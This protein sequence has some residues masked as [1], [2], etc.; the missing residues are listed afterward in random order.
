MKN[1]KFKIFLIIIAIFGLCYFSINFI[2]GKDEYAKYKSFLT[3]E[4]RETIKKYLFPSK[5][6]E[7][8]KYIISQKDIEIS[9]LIS[10]L[11]K[12]ELSYK[13]S[14]KEIVTEKYEK[15]K[16]SN[17]KILKKYNLLQGFYS[18]IA[19]RYP[20]SGYIDFHNSNLFLIS[21]RGLLVFASQFEEKIYF[22]QIKN[23]IGDF[24]GI[25]QFKKSYKYSIKDLHIYENKI[26]VSFTEEIKEDCWNT[27]ILIGE[28]NYQNIFF[29]KL[30]SS[31][32]CINSINNIDNEFEIHQSGGRIIQYDVDNILF[33]I[34]D[35]RSRFLSQDKDS[36]NG[37]IIKINLKTL[38]YDLFSMGHRNPQ[39]LY[40]D[41]EKNL[42]FETEH[43]PKG[44][45]EINLLEIN[46]IN[47]E[48]I[49][50]F[51]WPISSYGE[52]YGAKEFNKKKY[53]KYPL[54]KSH[55]DYGFIEPLKSFQPSI[56]ISEI[57]KISKNTYIVSSLKDRSLYFFGIDE[58]KKITS[59]ERISLGERI[60]DL[61]FKDNKLFLFLEDTASI[62]IINFD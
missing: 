21:A 22:Q 2:L 5:I 18:G 49:L 29:K 42:I 12:I 41:K 61:N 10:N 46:S 4:Q 14:G 59:M 47:K 39:G 50:N 7:E 34:G 55:S 58:D 8:Q 16:L 43:G 24:I 35:Y 9:N 37:K 53:K 13:L 27:S 19:L 6:I 23:N 17:N 32:D 48:N 15:I 62:G 45:D 31:K 60:R 38:N 40:F 3:K 51:G 28:L 1:R 54:Y 56:G 57:T 26:Y 52:H 25:E 36:I 20:G 33:S 44:G 30:F 11:S